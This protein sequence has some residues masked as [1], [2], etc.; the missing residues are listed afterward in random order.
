MLNGRIVTDIR[1]VP[2]MTRIYYTD[3]TFTDIA[4]PGVQD[5]M[6]RM[7][8]LESR[9]NDHVNTPVPAAHNGVDEGGTPVSG[10]FEAIFRVLPAPP[11]LI[12]MR[13]NTQ[14]FAI[15]EV[16]TVELELVNRTTVPYA[17]IGFTIQ[18]PFGFKFFDDTGVC[19]IPAGSTVTGI[20]N[21]DIQNHK[22]FFLPAGQRGKFTIQAQQT[23]ASPVSTT[24]AQ[25][26]QLI[27]LEY[28]PGTSVIQKHPVLPL[29]ANFQITP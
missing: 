20:H 10:S 26:V 27:D 13:S 15:S 3:D 1:L 21:S 11:A 2:P 5:Y 4:M 9:F 23:F 16:F 17:E 18:A 12:R 7:T 14:A 28:R 22:G 6:N 25:T 24:T 8:G 19:S 29:I